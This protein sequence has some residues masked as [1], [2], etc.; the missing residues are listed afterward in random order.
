M[1]F[2]HR[3]RVLGPCRFFLVFST[4]L[5]AALSTFAGSRQD[6]LIKELGH[7]KAGATGTPSFVLASTD[8][9]DPCKVKGISF[10]R[11]ARPFDAFKTEIENALKA[12]GR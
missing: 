6:D 10:I 4:L 11:G 3:N 9:N 12:S 1:N 2:I 7:R 8:P 5:I